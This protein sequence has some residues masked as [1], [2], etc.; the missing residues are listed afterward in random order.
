MNKIFSIL[1]AF[2]FICASAMAQTG[3]KHFNGITLQPTIAYVNYQGQSRRMARLLFHEGKNF[4]A[5]E[6]T[7]SFNGITDHVIIPASKEGTDVFEL[8]LPGPPITS[9]A[10]VTVTLN[11]GGQT[12][13]ARCIVEP[14]RNNWTMYILPHSHV[15]IGYTNTQA[16]VLKLHMDN[17]DEAIDLAKKTANYP[18]EARYK[19]TTEA[20]WAV[21][22]Y[23]KAADEAKKERFWDAVKKGWINLDGA[24]G[25]INTSMTDSYQLMQMFAK[26]QKLAKTHGV[27][28]HSMFQGDVPGASWGLAAQ[29]EQTGIKYFLSGPNASDRIGN[30]AK[31]Q[32]KPFYWISPSGKQKLL[33]WQCQPYSIGYAL[34]G[35]RIPNFFTIDD[36]KPFYTGHPSDNFLNPHLFQYLGGLEQNNFPYNMSL[37]TWAMSDNAPIDPELPDA[38]KSWN[39]HFASPKLV[40]TSVKQFFQDFEKQYQDKIPSFTGDYTEYWTD[41]VSS[42]AKE[43]AISRQTSDKLKQASALWAIRNKPGYPVDDFDDTW[44]NL[45]LYNEHTWGAYNSVSDPEDAKVKSEWT[46]KKGYALSAQKQTDSLSNLILAVKTAA[47]N[48]VDVYNTLSWLRTDVVYVPAGLS[49]AGD[50]VKDATGNAIPSQRLSSGELAFV[51]TGVPAFG[52][53]TYTINHGKA[54]VNGKAIISLN[55]LANGFYTVTIDSKTGDISKLVKTGGGK[56]QVL[57][58]STGFNKYIYMPGDSLQRQQTSTDAII[59]I[60]ENGPLVV[61][62]LA[63]S[64]APGAYGLTREIRL[65]NGLDKIEL[66]NTIDKESIRTKESVHFAF[67]FS[68]PGAQVRYS[69]PWGSA[70]AEADQ[71]PNANKNWFTMQRWVDVSNAAFGITWSSPDAPLFEIGKITTADLLGGLHHAPQWL[72]FTA[73][74]PKIYS[75]V[76]NNL[77]HT[78]FRAEQEKG[79]A[80]FRYIFRSHTLGYDSFDANRFG[81]S[82]HQPLIVSAS[83]NQDDEPFFN[84]GGKQIYIESL[85]PADDGNGVIAQIVSTGD[86]EVNITPKA[87]AKIKIWKSNLTE[88]KVAA[89]D[90]NFKIPVKGIITVRIEK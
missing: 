76:M 65:V 48:K 88:E 71:L 7:V 23:L 52:K 83:D 58:D 34:K 33:F 19:W 31:W 49:K 9:A 5:T 46:I 28:I 3:G 53:K 60:K 67:P 39:E 66:I 64:K 77:W 69:I 56:Q 74:S 14:A 30:L 24:Y 35:T 54:F 62:L 44:K 16:K 13:M 45:L 15:D 21:D 82:N 17:I 40:I 47:A 36:P 59:S 22:N 25:N 84:I 51:A 87:K 37:L 86:S 11:A 6:A 41:G 81:L 73:Q 57:V 1:S 72:T 90:N 85:K 29:S 8:P 70:A 42:A 10:Q 75:W 26:S 61:S 20:I 63:T 50:L 2:I 38:V 43:T 80:T 89:L 68:V 78:N 4:A 32:D 12:Y 79:L 27:E 18:V 55:G